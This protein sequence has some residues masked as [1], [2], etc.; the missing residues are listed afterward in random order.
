[1]GNVTPPMPGDG[2]YVTPPGS[3]R[4]GFPIRERGET[5]PADAH[6]RALDNKLRRAQMARHVRP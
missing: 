3:G 2:G 5:G 6:L 1:M 4:D